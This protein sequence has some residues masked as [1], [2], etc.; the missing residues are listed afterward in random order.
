[1]FMLCSCIL[2]LDFKSHSSIILNNYYKT[3]PFNPY[4]ILVLHV[5]VLFTTS[6][7]VEVYAVILKTTETIFSESHVYK[8]V[9]LIVG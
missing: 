3:V 4:L 1:M 2:S 5:T 7:Y 6:A 8:F 9:P